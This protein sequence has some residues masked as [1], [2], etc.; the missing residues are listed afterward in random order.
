MRAAVPDLEVRL[1][2]DGV[3]HHPTLDRASGPSEVILPRNEGPIVTFVANFGYLPNVDAALYLAERIL[4]RV[5]ARVP[6]VKVFLVG[7]APPPQIRALQNDHIVV[8]GRVPSVEP[9]LDAA[10]VVVCPLREGGGVKVKVLEALRRAKAVVTTSVGAQGLHPEASG[11]LVVRDEPRSF[12]RAVTELLLDETA[13]R[14]LEKA[15]QRFSN[16]LPT[17]EEAARALGDCYQELA[18][19]RRGKT[20]A[21]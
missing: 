14:Q 9:Y 18:P 12:A 7:N 19:G 3:D 16:A 4:P 8:T 6:S 21:T 10:D 1:V 15:A 13:R 2:P 11:A 17:W 20:I 5:A